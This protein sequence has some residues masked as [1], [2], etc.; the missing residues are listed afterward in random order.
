M[1]GLEPEGKKDVVIYQI[2]FSGC[3]WI[4]VTREVFDRIKPSA[5]TGSYVFRRK[6][7]E[8]SEETLTS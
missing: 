5:W 4:E 3:P 6:L 1:N 7:R 2:R 8:V